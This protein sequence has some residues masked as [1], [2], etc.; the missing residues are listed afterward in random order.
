[1]CVCVCVGRAWSTGLGTDLTS[2]RGAAPPRHSLCKQASWGHELQKG[3]MWIV[4]A[5]AWTT[6]PSS[7]SPRESRDR[8]GCGDAART[9]CPWTNEAPT[10]SCE[11]KTFA[12]HQPS[13][14][15]R[16][17]AAFLLPPPAMGLIACWRDSHIPR[18]DADPAALLHPPDMGQWPRAMHRRHGPAAHARGMC[19]PHHHLQQLWEVSWLQRE[20]WMLRWLCAWLQLKDSTLRS[21]SVGRQAL[22]S[23]VSS[24]GLLLTL[25]CLQIFCS[26]TYEATPTV[27]LETPKP[28]PI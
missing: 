20:V 2:G 3:Q 21:W 5:P 19:W 14:S 22:G 9:L 12:P 24:H 7:R 13:G 28:N 16:A 1:M 18:V 27:A 26:R 17:G 11:T 23:S 25:I 10:D 8:A 4:P 6:P 15:A